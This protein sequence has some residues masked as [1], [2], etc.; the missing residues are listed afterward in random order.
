VQRTA[1]PLSSYTYAHVAGP[2]TPNRSVKHLSNP[3]TS[4]GM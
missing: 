1:K 2:A 3:A 4:I